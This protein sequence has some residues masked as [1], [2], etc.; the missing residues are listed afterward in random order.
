MVAALEP[1]KAFQCTFDGCVASFDTQKKLISHKK[2]SDEHDYCAKCDRDFDSYDDLAR[3]K[4]FAPDKHEKACRICGEEF[5][6]T[7]GL[8]RHIEL[9]C[10]PKA[11]S[12][13]AKCAF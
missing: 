6:S 5:K 3:H 4:A 1:I 9:V 2:N 8:R 12:Y 13:D 7:S 11:L 10:Y